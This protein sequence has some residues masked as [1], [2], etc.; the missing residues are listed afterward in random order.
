MISNAKNQNDPI[1]HVIVLMLENRSFDQ[2]L[3][4]FK[5]INGFSSLEGVSVD[6]FNCDSFDQSGKKY[7]QKPT[8]NMRIG[9]DPGHD[10]A[11]V[12]GQIAEGGACK[13]FVMDYCKIYPNSTDQQRQDIMSYYDFGTLP[14][15]HTL[16][17]SFAICDH[18]F[19]S[20]P[21]PTWP[22]RL[23]VHSGTS[24]GRVKMPEGH[25]PNM[26]LYDQITLYD[27]L[28]EK[29]I[30]WKI[31]YGDFPQ[32]LVLVH[33]LE[34][35]NAVRYHR[36]S[37]FYLDVA[38]GTLPQYSFIEPSYFSPYVNSQH[39]PSDV[40]Q[41]EKLISEIYNALAKSA[42]WEKSLFI[43]LYDEHGG[44]YDH[45]MPKPA[46]PPD[47]YIEEFSFD[48]YGVRVPAI[49]ISP[50]IQKRVIPDDFDHA[51]L[52]KYLIDKWSL[53]PLGNRAAK[54]D[55]FTQY[56]DFSK[57]RN[58][59]PKNVIAA[60]A[61][62]NAEDFILCKLNSAEQALVGFSLFLEGRAEERIDLI[63]QR[64]HN[65]IKGLAAQLAVAKNRLES[66]LEPF[67][68]REEKEKEQKMKI[69]SNQILK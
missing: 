20:L 58:D 16:A 64:S 19:S 35:Y 36:M 54:A 28:N 66:F 23:F 3:G 51:S 62:A 52:L 26:H 14:V 9:P 4:C 11:N 50:W 33:Q 38:A 18:W 46:I 60:N 34:E 1:E 65:L 59:C 53:G 10:L 42:L 56:F 57:I 12:L 61:F 2:M 37:Q 47:D 39:P 13:G 29:N 24:K 49:I 68:Q 45:V 32:S 22:N 25:D 7:F 8:A 69:T 67:R 55:T 31:Y 48:K 44:F 21:G 17:D 30:S 63:A 43:L 41:G 6:N 27:R 5:K 15:L 40:M